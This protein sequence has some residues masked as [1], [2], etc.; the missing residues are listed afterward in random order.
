V[1]S[2][3]G[4]ALGIDLGGTKILAA[5]LA[6]DGTVRWQQRV[7]TPAGDYDATVATMAALVAAARQAAGD[8]PFTVGIGGPGA[9]T[10]EGRVKNANSTCLN[11]R[12]LLRDVEAA[13]GQPARYANDANCLALSEATDGAGAGHGVVFA[14]I[15]GTGTGAGIAVNGRVLAG[16]H[17]L[18]GE[19]GH[20]PLPWADPTEDPMSPC[21][22][23]K[24][25]CVETFVCGPGIA[26]DHARVTG[27]V[28]T[29]EAVRSVPPAVTRRAPPRWNA[30]PRGSRG[31]WPR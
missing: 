29:A 19:W 21:F 17:R 7:G 14:A 25:G 26:H 23:G 22:C 8:V 20:N 16:P 28:L 15:L 24:S 11:G 2:A 6:P 9:L 31:R 3:E 27:Q 5:L 30:T 18:S 4:L 1:K 13:I 10:A 12:P